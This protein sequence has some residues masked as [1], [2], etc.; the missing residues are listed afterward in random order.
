LLQENNDKEFRT[1]KQ[2]GAWQR[3]GQHLNAVILDLRAM[4]TKKEAMVPELEDNLETSESTMREVRE[5]SVNIKNEQFTKLQQKSETRRSDSNNRVTQQDAR[6]TIYRN[7]IVKLV[8][9]EAQAKQW[10]TNAWQSVRKG[11]P[12][13]KTSRFLA[14]KVSVPSTRK[15]EGS[16]KTP[17][18]DYFRKL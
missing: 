15:H 18:I 7:L 8:E 5:T 12:K 14:S 11:L 17:R 1:K 13:P 6:L 3:L 10:G 4:N 2:D 16:W 9:E